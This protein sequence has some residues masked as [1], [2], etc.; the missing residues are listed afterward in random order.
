M[1]ARSR[2]HISNS[3]FLNS[4]RLACSVCCCVSDHQKGSRESNLNKSNWI[5]TSILSLDMISDRLWLWASHTIFG[6]WASYNS[7][8]DVSW[9]N[10]IRINF[11]RQIGKSNFKT[12]RRVIRLRWYKNR[13][14]KS[15]QKKINFN[16][17]EKIVYPILT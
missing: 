8:T 17:Y 15:F 16:L 12:S 3:S 10:Y 14:K 11:K 9:L 5:I 2:M 1:E 6:F 4:L 13:N 7:F